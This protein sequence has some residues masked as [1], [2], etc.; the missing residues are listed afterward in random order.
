MLVFLTGMPGSGKTTIGKELAK[1]LSATLIDLDEYI[2]KKEKLSIPYIFKTKG[3]DYFRRAENTCLKELVE[4]N[5]NA[6][7]SVGGGTP[8]FNN[9]MQIMMQGGKAIYLK[10]KPETLCKR[11]EEDKNPRP[12]FAK[13]K[14]DKLKDKIVSMLSHREKYYLK[15]IINMDTEGKSQIDIAKEISALV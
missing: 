12:L 15:A 4:K 5:A 11:I 8:C 14:G 1:L 6:V 9:N 3:E 2:A 7:V 10:A 13:L